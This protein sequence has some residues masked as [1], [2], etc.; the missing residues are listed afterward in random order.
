MLSAKHRVCCWGISAA[1]AIIYDR[2]LSTIAFDERIFRVLLYP[3]LAYAAY[4]VLTV[5]HSTDVMRV[6]VL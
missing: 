4:I 5:G 3:L 6:S 2:F 1:T